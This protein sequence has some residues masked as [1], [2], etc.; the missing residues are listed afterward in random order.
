MKVGNGAAVVGPHPGAEGVE[1]P[2]D[3]RVDPLLA[4]VGHGERL[5]VALGLVVDAARADRVDVPPVGLGLGMH[6]RIA[7]D[8]GG[9][10]EEEPGALDLREAER[11]VGAVGAHPQ[12][13]QRQ[14]R[15]VD[16]AGRRGH[17]VDEVDRLVD[18][19]VR[20]DVDHPELEVR[21]V[22]DV[23]DVAERA[24]WRGCPRRSPGVRARVGSRRGS[25]RGSRRRRSRG[26][27]ASGGGYR[28]GPGRRCPRSPLG[29]KGHSSKRVQSPSGSN[30]TIHRSR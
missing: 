26:R 7:V 11:V 24:R 16:R 19:V 8:L 4:Q 12:R 17:V 20:R 15:V 25:S 29:Q 9:G 10:G 18:L 27:W 13:V 6:E 23:L 3:A 22:G 14:P 30:V 5:G 21:A 2:D 1:D 28:P